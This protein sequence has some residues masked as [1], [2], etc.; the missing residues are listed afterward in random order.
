MYQCEFRVH[1]G[2]RFESP[3]G[4]L[5]LTSQTGNRIEW[6]WKAFEKIGLGAKQGFI[7]LNGQVYELQNS[8]QHTVGKLINFSLTRINYSF[9]YSLV[10]TKTNKSYL[11]LPQRPMPNMDDDPFFKE[12]NN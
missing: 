9:N 11:C 12:Q 1:R 4:I 2:S 5:T 6:F 10:V 3:C 8:H 7:K